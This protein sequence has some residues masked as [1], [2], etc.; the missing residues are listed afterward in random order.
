MRAFLCFLAV[1]LMTAPAATQAERSA[2]FARSGQKVTIGLDRDDGRAT[3][4]LALAAYG[5]QWKVP[6]ATKDGAVEFIAPQVRVPVAFQLVTGPPAEAECGTLVVYPDRPISWDRNLQL[7]ALHAPRWFGQWA[8]AVALPVT[9][10]EDAA[11]LHTGNWRVPEKPALLIMA[12]GAAGGA[13]PAGIERLCAEH[14]VNVLVLEADWFGRSATYDRAL[15]VMPKHMAGPLADLQGQQWALPPGFRRYTLPWPGVANR[16][17]WIAGPEYPLVDT[18]HGQRKGAESLRMVLSYLPW[19]EQ[20]GRCEMADELF[21]RLLV[22]AAKGSK[23]RRLDDAWC[24]LYPAAKDIKPHER[25]V[26]AAALKRAE[27]RFSGAAE[28]STASTREVL[29]G[30]RP[31]RPLGGRAATGERDVTGAYV[32]DLRGKTPPP[33]DLF[34]RCGG[35]KTFEARINAQSPLLILG[36]DP[37]LDTWG[38]LA[39][40]RPAHRSS[41]PGVVWWPDDCLPPSGQSQLRL[42]QLFTRWSISLGEIPQEPDHEDHRNE[43]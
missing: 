33:D 8:E 32:L 19:E 3:E 38:W 4:P 15:T 35:M 9:R 10:I 5:R 2:R 16:Q 30:D 17:T 25:P 13:G 11:A 12:E 14:R 36:D 7:A 29:A 6:M 39:L 37:L 43:R 23:D 26:L 22:E 34:Q 42:M 28:D 27:T 40:D 31:D 1:W 41:R 21:I 20:L 18:I 24:L